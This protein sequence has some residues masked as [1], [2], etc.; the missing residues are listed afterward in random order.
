MFRTIELDAR[1]SQ[2]SQTLRYG[3][4]QTPV[5]PAL[6]GWNE[7][8]I[9]YLAL[10]AQDQVQAL[11]DLREQGLA[12][13]LVQDN[14]GAMQ[15]LREVFDSS[16]SSDITIAM[17]GTPFQ[18]K[19]WQELLKIKHAEQVSYGEIAA[20]LGLSGAARAVGSAVGANRIAYLIPCHRVARKSGD[21][22]RFRWGLDVK[23]ELCQWEADL[24]CV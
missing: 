3:F 24:T 22:A 15:L 20:R 5:G 13:T 14:N 19:V 12:Q 18:R 4:G 7:R 11:Q 10:A 16:G 9:W 2:N 6:I 23:R 17:Q 1:E 8:T 21:S